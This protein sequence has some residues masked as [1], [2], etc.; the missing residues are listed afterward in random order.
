M[1]FQPRLIFVTASSQEEAQRLA[2]GLLEKHLAACVSIVPGIESHYWWQGELKA[3]NEVMIIIKSSAQQFGEVEEA[4][5]WHHSYDC[6]EIIAVAPDQV[7][8]DYL[9]WWEKET[10]SSSC[11]GGL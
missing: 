8:P 1:S 9:A 4:I 7:A 3:A 6:P 11:S 10:G 2:K 5:R